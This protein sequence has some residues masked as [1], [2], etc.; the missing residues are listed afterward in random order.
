MS[1]VPRNA[2]DTW[3]HPSASVH[4]G[5]ARRDITPPV[6]IYARQWGA[7]AH[8]VAE[9][10]HRP[11]CATV[12]ALRASASGAPL[13]LASL[14]AG[15]W[16]D[17]DDERRLRTAVIESLDLDPARV[18]IALSHTHAACSICTDDTDKPGGEHVAPYL[19]KITQAVV[20]A[21]REAL[22][23][24]APAVLEWATG[25]CD[26]AANRDLP[27][28][29]R[30]ACGFNPG[31]PA[32]DTLLVGRATNVDG[33][34]LATVVN[35]A[36]HPTTLAW[37]NRLVSPDYIGA[38]RELIEGHTGGGPCLF[39]QGASGDL[40]P[41]EGFTGDTTVADAN[42][43]RLGHAVVA[44][45]E[46]MLSPRTALA[47]TGVVESGAPIA[48]W[49]HRPFDPPT[50]L[51]VEQVDIELPL[52]SLPTEDEVRRQL[53]TCTDRVQSER[54]RRKLRILRKVGSGPSSPV[55]TWFW[56]IG[57]AILVAHPN[58]CY[59]IFQTT[60]RRRFPE[61]ALP[62]VTVVNG[63]SGYLSLPECHDRDLYQVWQSPFGRDALPE[64]IAACGE[65]I[66]RMFEA[67]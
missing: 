22:S 41:R 40:G 4:I 38:M 6:G 28:G 23:R 9:G 42:G 14:D 19:A 39:L 2:P 11:L 47:Y 13:V 30:Y 57:D 54:L 43:R 58:E 20:D 50:T 27:V 46:A 65:R 52:K 48:A 33:R 37:E 62:V 56:R 67:R 1:N 7:A 34:I 5:V 32:D 24:T 63:G 35:Y 51:T 60:L 8:D 17:L 12:M 64:L 66:G 45:L 21:A 10:I 59:S 31:A 26:L 55:P 25:R 29:D 49:Q 18:L 3:R 16:Q 36:C 53:D 15:W 61:Y 44:T